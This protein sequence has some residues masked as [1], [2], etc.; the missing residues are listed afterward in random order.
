MAEDQLS[1]EEGTARALAEHVEVRRDEILASYASDLAAGDNPFGRDPTV[2]AAAL[3]QAG[4][5]LTDVVASLRGDAIQVDQRHKLIAV[6]MWPPHL[7][8]GLTERDAQL[9]A[10]RF[11]EVALDAMV[12]GLD[13]EAERAEAGR[14]LALVLNRSVGLRMSEAASAHTGFVLDRVRDALI[15]E[16]NHLARELHDR[17]GGGLST[18][19]RQLELHDLFLQTDRAKAAGRIPIATEAIRESIDCLRVIMSVLRGFERPAGFEKELAQLLDGM[20]SGGPPIDL[21]VSGDETWAPP[22]VRD[23]VLRII[24]AVVRDLSAGDDVSFVAVSVNIA[25]HELTV[26]VSTDGAGDGSG[27]TGRPEHRGLMSLGE[28]V[29]R[30]GGTMRTPP[31]PCGGSYLVLSIPLRGRRDGPTA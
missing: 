6:E 7:L 1:L 22:A 24:A 28:R 8:R 16:R 3:A 18:A 31:S 15:D 23:G 4:Q 25:A 29:T 10:M 5:V 26:A 21:R 9:A 2:R 11:F 12:A 17:V 20:P 27:R 14:L 13:G 30:L 19:L